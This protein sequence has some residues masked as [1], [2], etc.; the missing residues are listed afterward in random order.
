[1]IK[2]LYDASSR[3]KGEK[4]G[5]ENNPAVWQNQ[6]Y[7]PASVQEKIDLLDAKEAAIEKLNDQAKALQAEAHSLAADCED[8]ADRVEALAIGLEGSSAEKLA[9]YGIKLRKAVSKKSA[10]SKNISLSIQ[11]DSDGIG[12][13]VSTQADPDA[14]NYEWH[15]GI[16]ADP[17]K[18]DLIPELKYFTITAK[19]S[20]V[21]D[22]VP[23]GVRVFYRVRAFNRAGQGPWSEPVSKVQ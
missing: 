12:F 14:D 7:S 20:L 9:V 5:M 22:D 15:K 19:S 17:T 4:R 1:M 8:Y 13:I 6:P 23:K 21:D 10:P 11:D 16:A 2:Y 18:T 3:L